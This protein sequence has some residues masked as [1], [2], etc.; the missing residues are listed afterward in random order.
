M[1]YLRR[2]LDEQ[3]DR[4]MSVHPAVLLAGVRGAGKTTTA[5]RSARSTVRLDDPKQAAAV[6]GD[7]EAILAGAETPLLIDEWQ[8]VPE[9]WDVVRLMVDEDRS[10]GRFILSGSERTAVNAPI[11]TGAGRFLQVRLR[12]MTL[13]ERR[14]VIPSISL[15][16]LAEQGIDAMRGSESP[17]SP[18]E[19]RDAAVISGLPGYRHLAEADHQE[20]LRNY[21]DLSASRDLAEIDARARSPQRVRRYLQAYGAVIGTTADQSAIQ[22]AAGV[23]RATADSYHDLLTR[24]GIIEELSA[25]SSNRLKQ[26]T[27]RPKRHFVDPALAAA[28]HYDTSESLRFDR[29]RLGRLFES[30]VVC[31]IRATSDALG[32]GWRFSHLRTAKGLHEVDMMADLPDGSVIAMEATAAATVDHSDARHLIW[33]REQLRDRFRAGL[34]IH[35]GRFAYR[36]DG[37][38]AVAPLGV[39]V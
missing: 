18:A 12:P 32:L 4:F 1:T 15:H 37:R 38:I 11:H 14:G 21:F 33:L 5:S 2:H 3:L 27:R 24:L 30:A 28:D 17:Y 35:P 34:I 29:E 10:P 8:R 6:R 22:Q 13:S 31:Q 16:Y 25:W 26:L 7:P 39:L 9:V 19:Q 23:A 36:L 20:T